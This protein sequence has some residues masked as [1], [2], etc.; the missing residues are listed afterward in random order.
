MKI[1]EIIIVWPDNVTFICHNH[2]TFVVEITSVILDVNGKKKNIE[3]CEA[4]RHCLK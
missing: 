2:L 1:M 4:E 3:F